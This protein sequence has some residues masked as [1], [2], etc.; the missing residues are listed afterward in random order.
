MKGKRGRGKVRTNNHHPLEEPPPPEEPPPKEDP[1]DEPKLEDPLEDEL[2]FGMV[3][4]FSF[5]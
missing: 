5:T 3:R 2:T 1:P 4:I